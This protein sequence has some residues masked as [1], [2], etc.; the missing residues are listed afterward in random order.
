MIG[1]AFAYIRYQIY[2]KKISA[3][4][5]DLEEKIN[6][7]AN[8]EKEHFKIWAKYFYGKDYD[9]DK[10][11]LLTAISG[12]MA[13]AQ[14]LYPEYARIAREEGFNDIADKF[15]MIAKIEENHSWKFE[16]FLDFIENGNQDGE[17]KSGFICLNCGYI[18][19]GKEVPDKCP[20]CDH[21]K[22]Y[23]KKI[24]EGDK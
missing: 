8:N 7:I 1:E 20:V 6:H 5:K 9:S 16:D 15:E 22:E 2:A 19:E 24:Y 21:P 12:E 23:F 3:T 18:H 13:E 17:Q 11:N 14:S 4:S 10:F